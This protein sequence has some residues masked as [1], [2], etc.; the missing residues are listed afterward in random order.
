METF[1]RMPYAAQKAVFDKLGSV[2]EIV[3]MKE[4]E[5]SMYWESLK[6]YRD[7]LAIGRYQYEHGREEGIK[8]GIKEGRQH[9]L[10]EGEIA[11]NRRNAGKMKALGIGHDMISQVTGL[12]LEEISQ[13]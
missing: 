5:R 9:G 1:D 12:S 6:V 10:A 4:P 3:A 7:N 13:L 2:A 8:E 11:A